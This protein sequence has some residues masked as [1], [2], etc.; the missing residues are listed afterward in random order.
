MSDSPH[1]T[2]TDAA[3]ALGIDHGKE[4]G[5]WLIDGNTSVETARAI[6][7]EMANAEF[8]VPAPLSGQW[9]DGMSIPRLLSELGVGAETT[10]DWDIDEI[11]SAYEEGFYS[12]YRETAERDV[13]RAA[14]ITD[15]EREE[16]F[17]G[18]VDCALWSS[19]DEDGTPIDE[20]HGPD[21]LVS[22]ALAR[23]R[24]DADA[25]CDAPDGLLADLVIYLAEFSAN[26]AGHDFWLT[27]NGH[28]AG[29]WDRTYNPSPL[30]YACQNLSDAAKVWG[31]A[32]LYVGDD[33]L[34]YHA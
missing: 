22:E 7:L 20:D 14:G 9:A 19:T 27:R 32:S 24:V 12:G 18:Y 34:L 26:G 16:F 28:G 4:A 33:G 10:S 30:Y 17:Q 31:E 23:M 25:F 1:T 2:T 15:D 13:Y 3:Y 8:D 11:A 29:F 6:L 5:S 21:D